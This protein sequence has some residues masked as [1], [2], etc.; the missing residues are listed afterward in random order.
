MKYAAAHADRA[1]PD[2]AAVRVAELRHRTALAVDAAELLA[3]ATTA[4]VVTHCAAIGVPGLPHGRPPAHG[5]RGPG[6]ASGPGRDRISRSPTPTACGDSRTSPI[7]GNSRGRHPRDDRWRAAGMSG[8]SRRPTSSSSAPG[9]AARSR[10]TELAAAG[11]K[12]VILERGPWL[13]TEEFTHD[14]R[15]GTYTRIVDYI[16]GDGVSV[17]AGNCVGGSSVVYFAA[18]LRAPSFVFDRRGTIGHRIWP[19]S[20]TRSALDPWYDRVEETLPVAQQTWN[21]V[22][23]AGGCLAAACQ[24]RRAHLQSGAGRGRPREVHELQLDAQRLPVRREAVDA[25]QLPARGAGA[26]RRDPAAARGA[27]DRPGARPGLPL[28]GQLHDGR[29]PATI[30]WSS[31][32]G[33]IEAKIVVLAA[34]AMAT[35]AILQRSAPLLGG[36]PEA[37][38]TLLL[39]ER[40]PGLDGADGRG[41]DCVRSSGLQREAR[42]R[43]RG[44]PDR[45][46]D[47]VDDVRLPRSAPSRNSAGTACS[48]STSRRSPTSWPRAACPVTRVVRGRQA[49]ADHEMAVLAD[50]A[51]DDRGRQRGCLRPAAA[52]RRLHPAGTRRVGQH[53]VVHTERAHAAGLAAIRRRPE[54]DHGKDGLG[55]HLAWSGSGNRAV[56]PPAG[57]LPDRRRPDPVGVRRPTTS[58]ADRPGYSSP[59]VRRC[60]PRLTVN[61]SLTIA[62]LAERATAAVIGRARESGV[63]V[64]PGAPPP[65]NA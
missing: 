5:R 4:A 33:V 18:A 44:A 51:G 59:T 49:D 14:L 21:D 56:R 11:A 8:R 19:K 27:D 41:Q 9:P 10:R 48:R 30:S 36:V 20:I 53:V 12:V 17:V 24:Q 29:R 25:A 45:Q 60:R 31:G 40:R 32:G 35:P 7:A 34:G 3:S 28:P 52:H 61:P 64:T 46:A 39:A 58:C 50:L 2:V 13:A 6:R 37:V 54:A 47:R 38:G 57:V 1:G 42:C 43:V 26:R 23:Y 62:A 55:Q 22:P 65:G 63:A 15:I 16:T